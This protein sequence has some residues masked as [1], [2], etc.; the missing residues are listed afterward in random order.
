MYPD[1]PAKTPHDV[2]TAG[3]NE[4]DSEPGSSAAPLPRGQIASGEQAS[5]TVAEPA[6]RAQQALSAG[7]ATAGGEGTGPTPAQGDSE[8]QATVGDPASNPA[9]P[10]DY[11]EG[12][13]EDG[14][15]TVYCV[16]C[17]KTMETGDRYCHACGWAA[18]RPLPSPAET[19]VPNPSRHSR[20]AALLLCI[21]LGWVGAHRF[22]VGKIGTGILW[23]CTFGIFSVGTI[24]DA[25]LIGTG[26]FRDSDG[27]RVYRWQ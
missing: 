12:T 7:A 8:T 9:T 25:V 14:P 4:S 18:D 16:R 6:T 5:E 20:L 2:G 3:E 19:T 10:A 27:R 13:S 23:L 21:L 24:Y 15:A 1:D 17:G 26:E 22:Y 11:E